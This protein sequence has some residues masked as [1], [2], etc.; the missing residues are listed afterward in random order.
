MKKIFVAAA[1]AVLFG[2]SVFAET[3]VSF[4]NKLSSSVV[5][6]TIPESGDTTCEFAGVKEK[7]S[8]EV[9]SDKVNASVEGAFLYTG[10][11]E[12]QQVAWGGE[13]DWY[14]EFSPIN[15]L[16]I[17]WSDDI[18]T[19][20]SYLPVV[21]D[22]VATGNMG[23]DF[24]L[25]VKPVTGL[26]LTAGMN[27][28]SI[29]TG[30]DAHVNLNFAADYNLKD[31]VIFGAS[32]RDVAGKDDFSCGGYVSVTAVKDLVVNLGGTYNGEAPTIFGDTAAIKGN[33]LTLGASYSWNALSLG[34]DFATN[35][36]V[37]LAYDLYSAAYVSYDIDPVT[38]TLA[39]G[40]ATDFESVELLKFPFAFAVSPSVAVKVANHTFSAGVD[41]VN[42]NKVST[43]LSFPV[44]WKYAF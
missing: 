44:S 22:N 29:F 10:S 20:G 3:N 26:R 33:L 30:S 35:F 36:G 15:M 43:T 41:I 11:E 5:N 37:D 28:T 14:V 32:F 25:L 6:V 31:Y 7:V 1:C 17:F 9:T 38:L 21:D 23:S 13:A 27:F 19:D 8:V 24:G 39:G 16:T 40:I 12:S 18:L 4:T 42:V 34:Y 2:A